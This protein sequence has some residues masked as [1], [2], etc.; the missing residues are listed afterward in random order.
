MTAPRVRC[1]A[2]DIWGDRHQLGSRFYQVIDPDGRAFGLCSSC[3]LLEYAVLG[4]S[5]ALPVLRC[6]KCSEPVA[7]DH[8]AYCVIHKAELDAIEFTPP[9]SMAGGSE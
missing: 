1:A 6:T 5:L 7:P 2:A 8:V 4:A 3:C 9:A